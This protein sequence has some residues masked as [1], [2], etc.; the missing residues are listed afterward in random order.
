MLTFQDTSFGGGDPSA[1]IM[2]NV[3]DATKQILDPYVTV[4]RDANGE[5]FTRN[6]ELARALGRT[7]GGVIVPDAPDQVSFDFKYDIQV[8]GDFIQRANSARILNPNFRFSS[9][10]LMELQFP[11]VS[12][13]FNERLRLKTEDV[14]RIFSRPHTL[15]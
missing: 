2:A 12:D 15:G 9:E 10:T 6:A 7:I 14:L 3:T 13:P 5:L 1:F 4:I 11:E 8:P